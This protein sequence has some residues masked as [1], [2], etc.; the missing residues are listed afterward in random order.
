M[1]VSVAAIDLGAS[2]GRVVVGP[3]RPG[4]A[5]T[6]R[7]SPGSPTARSAGPT[8]CTGTCR[9]WSTDSLAGLRARGRRWPASAST[10]GPSTTGCSAT[11]SC[12]TCRGATGTSGPTA[13][14]RRCTR[15]VGPDELYRRT[16]L[17]FLPFNT[18]YQLAAETRLAEAEQLLL[19]PDLVASALTGAQRVRAH[20]RLDHRPA[21]RAHRRLGR[22]AA[23]RSSASTR[24]SCRELV[25]PGTGHRRRTSGTPGRGG[26]L[27]RHRVGGRR[28]ADDRARGGVHLLRHLGPG[29][30]RARRAR[31]SPTRHARPTSPTRAASTGGSGS[32]PT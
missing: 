15:R 5:A 2:S 12:S 17:Q 4:P 3:R 22:R 1:D 21:R 8:V 28:R 7:R 10:R 29:R 25:D 11:G 9:G 23:G 16:G 31:W 30:R 6:S 20:Q 24:P 19:V 18:I 32:S 27:P 26:R 14:W 13:G